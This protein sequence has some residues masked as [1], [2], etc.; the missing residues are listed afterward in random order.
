M[1]DFESNQYLTAKNIINVQRKKGNN[2]D[3][4][5]K[6]SFLGDFNDDIK[7]SLLSNIVGEIS[8]EEWKEIVDNQIAE[9]E[10]GLDIKNVVI[11]PSA[12][13]PSNKNDY[14]YELDTSYGSS[15]S[16]YSRTLIN[17]GFDLSEIH[18]IQSSSH[19]ILNKLSLDTR[20]SGPIKGLVIG[21]VQSGKTANMAALMAMAADQGWNMFIILTGTI[22]NL[23]IQ[24]RNRLIKDLNSATNVSW[25]PIDNVNTNPS[26]IY[27]LNKLSL[28]IESKNRYLMV[29]LKNSTRLK[30]LLN[31][32]AKDLKNR[33]KLK[34]LFIDDE[35]DQA[36][37][38][39][40]PNKSD[41]LA[42]QSLIERTTINRLIV[43]MFLNKDGNGEV[44]STKVRALDY[45]AYT[46]TPYANILN[47]LPGLES[48]Y[49]ANFVS[50][51]P[52]S[53]KYFGPQQIF[54]IEG[55]DCEGMPVINNIPKNEVEQIKRLKSDSSELPIELENAICWFYCCL[56]TQRVKYYKKPI[57]MLIHTSQKQSEHEKIAN[58]IN[59]WLN[60]FDKLS[61]VIKCKE[62]YEKQTSKM[63]KDDFYYDYPNYKNKNI[64]DYLPFTSISNEL[65]N[66]FSKKLSSI[67]ID[68]N[69]NVNYTKGVH[70]CIDNCSHNY[71]EDGEHIR[72]LYPE[73]DLDYAPGFIV[74]GGATLSRGLTIEGL[75][76][77]YFLRTVKQ[78]D[79]L[80]QM[81]R[82]FGYRI[83]YEML[84]RIWLT[85]TT[86][87]QFEFLSVLDYELRLEMKNMEESGISPAMVGIRVKY[88]PQKSFLDITSNNK[89]KAA[90]PIYIDFSGI[91]TQTTIFYSDEFKLK[92][93]YD[94][95]L[96]FIKLL[97]KPS[98]L[99]NHI[100]S[101]N[102]I[103]WLNVKND[104]VLNYISKLEFPRND[105]H[106][107]DVKLFRNWYEQI[108][109]KNGLNKWNILIAGIDNPR[110]EQIVSIDGINIC[111]VNRSRK[112]S[113]ND[114]LIRIGALRAPKDW[115][116]D[117]DPYSSGL[118]DNDRDLIKKSSTNSYKVI[119]NKA[120]LLDT[121]LLV[122][123]FIDKESKPREEEKNRVSMGT[124]NDVIG[125]SIVVP[126]NNNSTNGSYLSVNISPNDSTL[127][128]VD[129]DDED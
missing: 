7:L 11:C 56:A 27:A 60:S 84:P 122:I 6:L 118:D 104:T 37:V 98:D 8:I 67:K 23:R 53:N 87:K 3:E 59:N 97:G 92:N 35:A 26:F 34:I 2:W 73:V 110:D 47:E 103:G 76:S 15:W 72:L 82:W 111:K 107:F 119:R 63:S 45:V 86:K 19:K 75:V 16:S 38:N 65:V 41:G 70:L 102:Y 116:V 49:P 126:N 22:E 78:A 36:G 71:V 90:I 57:S 89:K 30:N 50:C 39:T 81:G 80:M 64:D 91:S 40:T 58:L 127:T 120:G 74:I 5:K 51:L 69:R 13:I 121:S 95:T 112:N 85:E 79:T 94:E 117:V 88:L 24:T 32:M 106:F 28:N 33:E 109:P 123:Y 29:C 100:K 77:T 31:W 44:V 52:V 128:E 68:E 96:I 17:K 101:K 20:D 125:L 48:I 129:L 61:F 12:T 93:N 43:N 105:Y 14:D 99:S 54:G 66:I 46:A 115:Y 55:M 108:A 9:E 21:N 113:S 83:G 18:A 42:D 4:I 62:V 25:T 114:G 1:I 124:T 10:N